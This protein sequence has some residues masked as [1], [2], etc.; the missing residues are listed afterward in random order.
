MPPR[1]LEAATI[2]HNTLRDRLLALFPEL[3]EDERALADSLEGVS[4]FRDQVIATMRYVIEREANGEALGEIIK[5]MQAR[6]KRMEDGAKSLRVAVMN[7][8][9]EAG[10][11]KIP[12]PDF[13]LSIGN[14]KA[15]IVITAPEKVPDR[16]CKITREPSKSMIAD[17]LDAG[18]EVPG[19]QR[20]N[21]SMFLSVHRS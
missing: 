2:T 10:E 9:I 13:T 17:E 21:G 3:S 12:A 4:D 15:G 14:G 16:L 6:K 7:A 19:A 5:R 18:R 20:G 8:M 11:R 1:D